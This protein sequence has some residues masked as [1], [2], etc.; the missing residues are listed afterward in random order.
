MIKL[1]VVTAF[2]VGRIDTPFLA[3]GVGQLGPV[4]LDPFPTIHMRDIMSHE[5]HRHPYIEMLGTVYLMKLRYGTLFGTNAGSCW[6]LIF[7]YALMPW[8]QKYRILDTPAKRMD[9]Q[10]SDDDMGQPSDDDDVVDEMEVENVERGFAVS[11][12]IRKPAHAPRS[13]S[14]A[15]RKLVDSSRSAGS[16]N[17][18]ASVRVRVRDLRRENSSLRIKLA[19][20]ESRI[21]SANEKMRKASSSTDSVSDDC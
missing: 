20:M 9:H 5:A 15:P 12:E 1:I 21:K 16:G 6:R 17:R 2:S 19:E 11:S 10:P 13:I 8:M 7:V 3:P 18:K 14:Y 4:E